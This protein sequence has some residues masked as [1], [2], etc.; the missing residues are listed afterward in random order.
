MITKSKILFEFLKNRKTI[1]SLAIISTYIIFSII[2]L[3]IDTSQ[4]FST[5]FFKPPSPKHILGTDGLGRDI[6]LILIDYTPY[7][8]ASAF[9]ATLIALVIGLIVGLISGYYSG[10]WFARL[11]DRITDIILSLPIIIVI[12]VIFIEEAPNII[13]LILITGLFSWP[14]TAKAVRGQVLVV[15]EKT[16]VEASKAI[17]TSDKY[18]MFKVILPDVAPVAAASL[19][20]TAA[21]I[22][23]LQAGLAFLGF[24][25]TI[26]GTE[27]RTPYTFTWGGFLG[28]QGIFAATAIGAWWVIIPPALCLSLL[29]LSIGMLG[30]AV[31]ET[32]SPEQNRF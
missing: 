28:F 21:L 8:I 13:G 24:K 30:I 31:S 16:Y 12:G 32:L 22:V 4:L 19:I 18:I 29:I 17:G 6:L 2:A 15:R 7:T 23:L 14:I 27:A 9:A 20:Y 26:G 10:K 1:T 25:W 11:L 5:E 3:F